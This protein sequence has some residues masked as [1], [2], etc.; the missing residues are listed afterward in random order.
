MESLSNIP[1][2]FFNPEDIDKL[3]FGRNIVDI[4]RNRD[5]KN[6]SDKQHTKSTL[7]MI[8][9]LQSLGFSTVNDFSIFNNFMNL[10]GWIEYRPMIGECDGCPDILIDNVPCIKIAKSLGIDIKQVCY[11][12]ENR[13]LASNY[14]NAVKVRLKLKTKSDERN[15]SYLCPKRYI[16]YTLP[17]PFD[18]TWRI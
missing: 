17:E 2:S 18:L 9:G 6:E 13:N 15:R 16:D 14:Y 12:P 8:N 3:L 7:T 10:C 11:Y 1:R 5:T 4:H